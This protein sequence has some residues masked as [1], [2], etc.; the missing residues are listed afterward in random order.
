MAFLYAYVNV[1]CNY[2]DVGINIDTYIDDIRSIW[3]RDIIQSI[4]YL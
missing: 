4:L 1:G 3:Y 2:T